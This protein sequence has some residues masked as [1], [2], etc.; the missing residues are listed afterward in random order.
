MTLSNNCK[1]AGDKVCNHTMYYET[2]EELFANAKEHGLK[3][4]DIQ[5][6]LGKKK[7]LVI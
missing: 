2:E 7:F 6:R 5:K 3:N 1:D 4:M